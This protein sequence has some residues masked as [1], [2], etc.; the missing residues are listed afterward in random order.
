MCRTLSIQNRVEAL[1]EIKPDL[2]EIRKEQATN[3]GWSIHVVE[4]ENNEFAMIYYWLIIHLAF[5]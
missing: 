2:I 5:Q 4:I 3:A 1:T